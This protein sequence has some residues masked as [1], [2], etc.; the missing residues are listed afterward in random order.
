MN[1]PNQT[2]LHDEFH[3]VRSLPSRF[4]DAVTRRNLDE[5]RSCFL[6]DAT[7]E[8][9]APMSIHARGR[10]AI[11]AIFTERWPAREFIV[12]FVPS[13][14]VLDRGDDR[15]KLRSTMIEFGRFNA[16]RGLTLIGLYH[17]SVRK[18]GHGWAFERRVLQPLFYDDRPVS[19][20][21]LARYGVGGL[22]QPL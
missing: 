1:V 20:Q 9:P 13:T 22:T 3:D 14:I 16:D 19:G 15:A 18:A 6:P 4:A 11:L 2:S 7:W 17:D 10:D 21:V 12:Q 8:V 5:L